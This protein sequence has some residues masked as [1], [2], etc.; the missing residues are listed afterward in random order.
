MLKT[1]YKIL[2]V[3]LIGF[4]GG[5]ITPWALSWIKS[6]TVGTPSD[7]VAIANTYIVFTTIIFVGVTVILAIVGYVFTQQFSATKES[8]LGQLADELK[9]TAKTDEDFGIKLI[10]AMLEN[11]DVK[12]HVDNKLQE[13]IKELILESKATSK[14][15][16]DKAAEE[17]QAIESLTHQ[18]N[19]NGNG[20]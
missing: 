19:G 2:A 20:E 12:R 4:A 1:I 7:A 9:K 18:M 17:A 13:K 5:A 8:Q 3:F 10:N 16:L 6:A 15:A 14:Q 11:G